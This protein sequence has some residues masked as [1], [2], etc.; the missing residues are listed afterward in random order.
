MLQEYK[1]FLFRGNLLDLAVA[2]ILGVAFSAVVTTFTEG[3][4]MNPIAAIFGDFTVDDLAI[5]P[6]L[7]GPFLNAVI[8]FVIVAT[9]L[10]FLMRAAAKFTR[11]PVEETPAPESDEVLL[12]REIRDA[13]RARP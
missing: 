9:V 10:F 7:I 12:L 6:F 4:I 3:L 5:G 11:P 13:L 2:F 8:S 1:A